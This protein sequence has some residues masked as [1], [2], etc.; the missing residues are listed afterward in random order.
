MDVTEGF[1]VSYV[2]ALC[3]PAGRLEKKPSSMAGQQQRRLRPQIVSVQQHDVSEQKKQPGHGSYKYRRSG[4]DR[5]RR[6]ILQAWRKRQ[7][8]RQVPARDVT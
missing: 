4:E 1:T 5:I 2:L 8:M 7:T 6:A 3:T